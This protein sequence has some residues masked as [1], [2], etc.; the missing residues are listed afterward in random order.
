MTKTVQEMAADAKRL[1]LDLWI[2][3]DQQTGNRADL[4]DR[5]NAAIDDLAALAAP[6]QQAEPRTASVHVAGTPPN[7]TTTMTTTEARPYWHEVSASGPATD[8]QDGGCSVLPGLAPTHRCI[9]CGALW[10]QCDDGSW[11]L[12]VLHAGQCCD[13]ALMGEQIQP[14]C[15]AAPDAQDEA[16]LLALEAVT[17]CAR[18]L[19]FAEYMA[20]ALRS[21]IYEFRK[22]AVRAGLPEAELE[23]SV[24][25]QALKPDVHKSLL[26]EEEIDL[27]GRGMFGAG[28][29]GNSDRDFAR[30]VEQAVLARLAQPRTEEQEREAFEAWIENNAEFPSR[31]Q[32]RGYGAADVE[33]AK[34]EAAREAWLA[35]A[36]Q[37]KQGC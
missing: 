22:R 25:G 32:W 11:N 3:A 34:R 10:R 23:A 26:S 1:A 33:R 7:P 5:L 30:A 21:D 2:S 24:A 20:K 19:E 15:A 28:Y 16:G 17:G 4:S 6:V 35:R 14:L 31:R 12:R 9:H 29:G 27:I 13:N 37:E 8:A 36:Q 18:A